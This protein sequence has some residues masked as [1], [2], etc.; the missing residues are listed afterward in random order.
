MPV[1]SKQLRVAS[2]LQLLMHYVCQFII[3]YIKQ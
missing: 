3:K 1:V 2:K